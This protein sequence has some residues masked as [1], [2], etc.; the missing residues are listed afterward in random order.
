MDEEGDAE[1][2]AIRIVGASYLDGAAAEV[3]PTPQ[4]TAAEAVGA[5]SGAL[6]RRDS[7]L[8]SE[9]D[10]GPREDSDFG[11]RHERAS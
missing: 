6:T 7:I 4:P 5:S 3:G 2:A 8:G 1:V 11:T 10:H 9:S